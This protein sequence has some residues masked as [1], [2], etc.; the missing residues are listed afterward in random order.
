MSSIVDIYA[1]NA[2][3]STPVNNTIPE[4]N[5]TRSTASP[6]QNL[7]IDHAGGG[8]T[9]LQVDDSNKTWITTGNWD[10]VSNPSSAA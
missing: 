5:T 2:T 3:V 9:S 8:F 6:F 1:Q 10:L 7:T 4:V